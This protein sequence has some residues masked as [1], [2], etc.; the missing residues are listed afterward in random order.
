[1]VCCEEQI[2]VY[3]GAIIASCRPPKCY[4]NC[5]MPEPLRL[6]ISR[7]SITAKLLL[8]KV[9][10]KLVQETGREMGTYGNS[11]GVAGVVEL[12]KMLV[13]GREKRNGANH[14]GNQRPEANTVN[15]DNGV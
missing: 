12:G 4:A 2:S 8:K 7:V 9:K 5:L 10:E 15:S 3:I 6:S 13:E 11:L 1:M 14:L